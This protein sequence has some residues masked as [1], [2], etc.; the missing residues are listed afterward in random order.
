MKFISQYSISISQILANHYFKAFNILIGYKLV[1]K[2][3]LLPVICIVY[4]V[5]CNSS[6]LKLKE[7][8]QNLKVTQDLLMLILL[9]PST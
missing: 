8:I 4:L 9:N 2:V 1:V 5:T 6:R 7:A 3:N